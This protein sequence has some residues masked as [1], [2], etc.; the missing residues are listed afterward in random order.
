MLGTKNGAE[1]AG[2]TTFCQR[3]RAGRIVTAILKVS[4]IEIGLAFRS[5]G[6]LGVGYGVGFVEQHR[7][8][9]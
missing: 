5:P 6:R 4:R 2:L 1:S 3:L 8:T 7:E 9:G